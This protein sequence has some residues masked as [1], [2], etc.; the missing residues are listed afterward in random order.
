MLLGDE[1]EVEHILPFSETLDD[2]L[3]NKTV[4]M[5]QA[6]RVK[7]NKTPWAAFGAVS[8][9]GFDY[10]EIL[11][12][13]QSMPRAKRYRFAEDG[14][15]QWLRDDAGF[16]PRALNDTRYLSKVAK[17]YVSL[18]C[19]Q[20]TRVIPGRMTAMLRRQ[21]GLN[22]VLGH[23]GEKNRDDHRHH[24]VDACVIAVT[25]QGLLQRFARASASARER[26]LHRLVD[27][28]PL[29]WPS[30]REHVERAV[31][32]IWV[33]H[34]PDHGHEG[35]MHNDTAYA[36]LGDGKVRTTKVVDGVRV[37]EVATLSV[38]EFSSATASDRHG[39]HDDGR[40]LPYK[41]YKGDSNYCI[42][43]TCADSGRWE[44][45]I[46]STFESYQTVREKSLGVLRDPKIS[47]D[48]KPLVMRLMLNDTVRLVVDEQLRTMRIATISGNGQ[49]FMADVFEANVD[50]RNRD[51]ASAFK[52]VSKY[53]SSLQR[54]KAKQVSISSIGDVRV[55][56]QRA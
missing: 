55:L 18:I 6:N 52:Y 41:G 7:G 39:R 40:P 47:L 23:T 2:S 10:A 9:D 22:S 4:A 35:A 16:L 33:S 48:G 44:G 36:L 19:P 29:P 5:R 38:I 24:A 45:R 26:S 15:K 27:E 42:E 17:E 31:N 46:V 49:V 21:F 53:A 37:R 11:E 50:S 8:I 12:R 30:Y 34:K 28:M 54:A 43:I 3:N 1:V 13:A 20:N 32:R 51:K 14:Y 25:D 56:A